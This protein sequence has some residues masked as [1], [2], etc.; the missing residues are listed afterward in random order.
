MKNATKTFDVNFVSHNREAK[1]PS[2]PDFPNG[3]DIDAAAGARKT[4]STWLPYPAECCGVWM[5]EC[6][7]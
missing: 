1:C 4:C 2:N 7:R 3:V 5:I 6:T